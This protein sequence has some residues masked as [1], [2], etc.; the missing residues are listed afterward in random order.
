MKI[1]LHNSLCKKEE[2]PSFNL[3][4]V[5]NVILGNPLE[6]VL[7][8]R[9]HPKDSFP[10]LRF[11]EETKKFEEGLGFGEKGNEEDIGI[12]KRKN[13]CWTEL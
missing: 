4:I 7:R 8:L 9:Y 10:F 1:K 3:F 5:N 6:N 11:S 13:Y 2:N 12:F